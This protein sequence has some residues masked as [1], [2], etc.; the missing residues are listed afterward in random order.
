MFVKNCK[1]G[2]VLSINVKAEGWG[3]ANKHDCEGYIYQDEEVA[4]KK[5]DATKLMK[6]FGKYS[7]KLYT[8]AM[9]GGKP[10]GDP[11]EIWQIKPD[12]E[13]KE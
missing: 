4:K 8:Q 10:Q 2:Q 5:K 9:S 1:T 11:K 3:G 6:F 7:D 13:E 12:A